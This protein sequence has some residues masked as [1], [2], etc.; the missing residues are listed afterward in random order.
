MLDLSI[1]TYNTDDAQ[2]GQSAQAPPSTRRCCEATRRR[3]VTL[4]SAPNTPADDTP[5]ALLNNT[6]EGREVLAAFGPRRPGAIGIA[7][8][9]RQ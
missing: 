6:V 5:K 3:T 4:A 1:D 9:P 8:P 2:M 7:V